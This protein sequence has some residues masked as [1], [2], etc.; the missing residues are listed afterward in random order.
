M[1]NNSLWNVEEQIVLIEL[2]SVRLTGELVIPENASGIVVFTHGTG[3]SRY[4]PR[5]HYLAHMLRQAGLATILI[6]LLTK[7]EEVLDMRTKH[8]RCNTKFLAARLVGATD[9]LV[10][11]PITRHLKVGY[12]GDGTGGGAALIAAAE[13]PIVV[14]AI[15]SR[16]GL[17]W[18]DEA[19]K[20][21]VQAPTLLIVGGDDLPVIAMNEDVLAQI[22][23]KNK[24]LEIIKRATHHF[25][26]PGKTDEVARLA[27]LWFKHYLTSPQ[28]NNLRVYAMN[29]V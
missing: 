25:E 9:W 1:N 27:S 26:E 23:A 22:P 8:F 29:N 2:D 14:G 20:S 11:N 12:F 13:R 24:Q 7:E 3:S 10:E 28:P 4:S 17:I 15:V 21:Y 5:N 19:R 18:A 6:D 16:G